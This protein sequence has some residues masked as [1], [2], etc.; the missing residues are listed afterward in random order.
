MTGDLPPVVLLAAE[1]GAGNAGGQEEKGD[2]GGRSSLRDWWHN[3]RESTVKDYGPAISII[4][5]TWSKET[6]YDLAHGHLAIPDDVL[7]DAIARSIAGSSKVKSLS[8]TSKEKKNRLEIHADTEKAG[9]IELS[10]E[11]KE[12]VHNADQSYFSYRVR[13]RELEDHGLASWIFSRISLSMAQRL[14]GSI[15]FPDDLPTKIRHNTLTIDFRKVLEQSD[16]G[17]AELAGH[18]LID[19]V[20]IEE[21]MPHDGYIDI[22]TELHVPDDVKFMLLNLVL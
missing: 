19:M 20:E 21:A 15:E 3:L 11:I 22:R 10:G 17:K 1:A 14:F 12:F 4:R 18:R 8:I 7:N 5:A 6:L 13:E 16:M 2:G 9:R